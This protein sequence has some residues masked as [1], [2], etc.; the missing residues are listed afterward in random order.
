MYAVIVWW[1]RVEKMEAK[2]LLKS[3]RE[4]GGEGKVDI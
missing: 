1:L 4:G 2:N 3:L